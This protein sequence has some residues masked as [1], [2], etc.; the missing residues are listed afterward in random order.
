MFGRAALMTPVY[1]DFQ[2]PMHTARCVSAGGGGLL[3]HLLTL[4]SEK[5]A[6]IF[7]CTNPSSRTPSDWEAECPVLPGLSSCITV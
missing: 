1:A 4:T 3:P 5:E 2:P 6:V 7:F